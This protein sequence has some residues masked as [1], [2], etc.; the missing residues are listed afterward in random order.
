MT[1]SAVTTWLDS[2]M[3]LLPTSWRDVQAHRPPDPSPDGDDDDVR[4]IGDP[5]DDEEGDDGD[6][7]YDDDDD[8]LD[9]S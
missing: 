7:E 3:T 5:D 4:P 1:T 8:G 6:D 2:A 9:V